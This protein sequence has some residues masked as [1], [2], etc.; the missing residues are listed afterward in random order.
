MSTAYLNRKQVAF[1][2]LNFFTCS[3]TE[4]E[5][6]ERVVVKT[7]T[8]EDKWAVQLLDTYKQL[9]IIKEGKMEREISVFGDLFNAGILIKGIID[10]LQYSTE[11]QELILTDLKTRRTNTMP[12]GTQILG[13][14]LQLMVY[15]ILL[16]GLTRGT[17]KMELLAEHLKLNFATRLSPSVAD[18]ISD[19]GLQ[20]LFTSE[21]SD[22]T[23]KLDFKDFV[24][25]VSKLI[26]GLDLPPVTSL[27]VH[28][29]SQ[30]TNEVIGEEGAEFDKGWAR[31]MLNF[32]LQFWRGER[33]PTGPDIED[34]WKC[35]TCQFKNVCVWRKQKELEVSPGVK[36]LDSPVKSP[37]AAKI[38]MLDSPESPLRKVLKN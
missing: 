11:T 37:A 26:R 31:E 16:D 19:L 20:E 13:H 8:R 35:E 6:H 27:I 23:L 3:H 25:T 5:V 22:E 9:S 21:T 28:Y 34:M 15:K 10:Q 24:H 17:T 29:E 12:G 1:Y 38:Q 33:E 7:V 30:K 36:I 2:C 32:A 4:L 14:K 18:H